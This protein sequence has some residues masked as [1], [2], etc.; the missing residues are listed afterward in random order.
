MEAHMPRN[1]DNADL[2][3]KDL[4][5]TSSQGS[6]GSAPKVQ[7]DKSDQ[8]SETAK[9]R[10]TGTPLGGRT[11]APREQGAGQEAGLDRDV[12]ADGTPRRDEDDQKKRSSPGSGQDENATGSGG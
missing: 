1:P 2:N 3:R 4:D 5:Q 8:N 12:G 7:R 9:E 10:S 6:G 11:Q